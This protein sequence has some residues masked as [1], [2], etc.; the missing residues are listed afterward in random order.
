VQ[1]LRE[2]RQVAASKA[3]V[4]SSNTAQLR[5]ALRQVGP[6]ARR[7]GRA[8][9]ALSPAR[10]PLAP[11]DWQATAMQVEVRPSAVAQE[12]LARRKGQ[13][14]YDPGRVAYRSVKIHKPEA[15]STATWLRRFLGG[16][17]A[18]LAAV[19]LVTAG[20]GA[21]LRATHTLVGGHAKPG[22]WKVL[23]RPALAR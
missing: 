1:D 15:T 4:A 23:K 21:L 5:L 9:V 7:E 22:A 20:A 6:I 14:T 13:W 2:L 3:R 10:R 11:Q 16:F 12:A 17:A 19:V 8:T 18:A